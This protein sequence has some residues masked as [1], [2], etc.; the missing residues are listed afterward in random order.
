MDVRPA[1]CAALQLEYVLEG[2]IAALCVP[3]NTEPQRR[4][5]LWQTTCFELF[6]T[7]NGGGYAEFNFSPSS[8]WA[9]YRFDSYREGMAPADIVQ[10]S[11]SANMT[12]QRLVLSVQLDL[13]SVVPDLERAF[14]LSAV[15]EQ[16][17]GTK[18]WWALVHPSER[19]DFHHRDCFALQL[20]AA[21]QI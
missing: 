14:G 18:S 4:D 5:H 9:A 8:C 12:D 2:D 16:V 3:A 1:G 21:K 17:D 20:G 15:L 19:P 11:I 6:V 13:S 7:L 10:P